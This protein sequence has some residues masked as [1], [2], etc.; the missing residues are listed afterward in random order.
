MNPMEN[1]FGEHERSAAAALIG[2]ALNEDLR[3][4][5]DLT[6]VALVPEVQDGVV[7]IVAR[8]RGVVSGL[9]IVGL[10][11]TR[12]DPSVA[13]DL[14]CRDGESVM[15][16][17]VLA[18]VQGPVRSLLT[19]ER[20]VLNFLTALGGVATLTRKFVDAAESA[21]TK[22]LDTRKTWPGWRLL[23][24][25]AVRCG[26]G[27]NHRMGLSDG[28]LIKD[29]HLAAWRTQ[30]PDGSVSAAIR[31]ARQRWPGQPIEVEV[32]TLAQLND[33]LHE[34]PEIVLLDNMQP[35]Q[36]REAVAIRDRF[37]PSVLLE[38]S[39]GVNLDTIR[40]IAATGVDRISIGALTHSAPA[41]DVAFDWGR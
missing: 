11:F 10:V 5:C 24:K 4:A 36:L 2:M 32:D 39:G 34:S 8:Q 17:R 7:Q 35:H 1:S 15:P 14:L 3:G 23:Q 27:T 26:G 37:S 21:H 19:G 30:A 13:V 38:A 28:I 22:I 18:N 33:A 31:Q 25:Y 29:N 41:L 16:G 12:I 20:T 40:E 6:S 9:P